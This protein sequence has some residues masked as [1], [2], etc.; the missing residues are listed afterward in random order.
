MKILYTISTLQRSGP[1][2]VLYNLICGL[3]QNDITPIVLTLSKEPADSLKSLFERDSFSVYSLS[4]GRISGFFRGLLKFKKFVRKIRPDIIHA[5]GFR[6]ICLVAWLNTQCKKV[7]T[8]HCDFDMDYPLKY[9]S[10]VGKIM[11]SL[12]WYALKRFAVRIC[13]S[14]SLADLLNKRQKKMHFDYVNNGVDTRAFYPENDKKTLRKT[15]GLPLEQTLFI[16]AGSFI[17]MK[18][19]LCLVQAIKRNR[20][21]KVFFIFCGARGPLFEIAR[22]ELKDFSNVFFVGYTDRVD[23]YMKASDCYIATSLSEGFHLT[24]YEAL[25]C[26]VPVILT[27]LEIYQNIKR[28]G[29]GL[30]FLPGSE[31]E[32]GKQISFFMTHREKFASD[33]FVQFIRK[34]FSTEVMSQQYQE[35]YR[36]LVKI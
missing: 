19:P 22:Q 13:V 27:D 36:R 14:Q 29:L 26:G 21:S 35:Y 28:A 9:G 18:D 7:A 33:D 12:Q 16:W 15:L 11:A 5:N 17:Q 31:E 24:V 10:L 34:G 25:S 3:N 6:D 8:I 20:N 1:S 4:L 32:L 30:F 2:L 23:L